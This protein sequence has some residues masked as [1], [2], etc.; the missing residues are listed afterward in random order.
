MHPHQHAV[1][2]NI[3]CHVLISRGLSRRGYYHASN[4]TTAIRFRWRPQT[5]R[6]NSCYRA[7]GSSEMRIVVIDMQNVFLQKVLQTPMAA[8]LFLMNKLADAVRQAGEKEM[9][10]ND[11]WPRKPERGRFSMGWSAV[12]KD[13]SVIGWLRGLRATTLAA[14]GCARGLVHR[15]PGGVFAQGSSNI[16]KS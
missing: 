5:T 13:S 1:R 7:C 8:R 4:G 2:S 6:K 9:G 14:D 11:A 3:T 16:W 15:R 12:R 10:A